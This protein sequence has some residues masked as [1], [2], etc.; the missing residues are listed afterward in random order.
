MTLIRLKDFPKQDQR[1]LQWHFGAQ[2]FKQEA[3]T[4]PPELKVYET[5]PAL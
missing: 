2:Q 3:Q 4:P 5:K 1:S